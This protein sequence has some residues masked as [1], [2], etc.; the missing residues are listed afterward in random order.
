[1]PPELPPNYQGQSDIDRYDA[2]APRLGRPIEWGF[3]TLLGT[4]EHDA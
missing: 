4:V 1:L 3:S 2:V